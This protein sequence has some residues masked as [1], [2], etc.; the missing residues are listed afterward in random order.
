MVDLVA[1][2]FGPSCSGVYHEP[3]LGGGSVFLGLAE[4]G[5]IRGASLSDVNGR[6]IDLWTSLTTPAGFDDLRAELR[7][8]PWGENWRPHYDRIRDAFNGERVSSQ[9]LTAA[10]LVWLNR[11]CF[12]GLYRESSEGNFNT[13]A[14][15][16]KAIACPDEALAAAHVLL[17]ERLAAQVTRLHWRHAFFGSTEPAAGDWVFADPPYYDPGAFVAYAGAW[18]RLDQDELVSRLAAA[19]RRGARVVVTQPATPKVVRQWVAA[20][21]EVVHEHA[22]AR[23]IGAKADRRGAAAEVIL[24]AGGPPG[25]RPG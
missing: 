19:A 23:P 2:A 1:E 13:Q 3:F 25:L 14:G 7:A 24:R 12:N 18:R 20:G 4:A 17:S 6:L 11:A 5:R 21:F 8:L 9:A 10:R 16:Y 22:V 15:D